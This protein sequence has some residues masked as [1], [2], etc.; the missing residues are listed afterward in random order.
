MYTSIVLFA[1]FVIFAGSEFGGTVALGIL[2]STTLIVAMFTNLIVLPALLLIFDDG[3]R[4]RDRHPIIEHYDELYD[5]D[6]DEEINRDL[7]RIDKGNSGIPS[8][9][10]LGS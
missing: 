2:A 6:N 10:K 5:E 9:K 7:I 3:K 1:G 4:R 8:E